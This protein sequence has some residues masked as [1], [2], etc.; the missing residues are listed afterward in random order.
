MFIKL[1]VQQEY[2][3]KKKL[4]LT[5]KDTPTQMF[6]CEYHKI[7]D[8]SFFSETPLVALLWTFL[9]KR[10]QAE[11]IIFQT[12]KDADV[13]LKGFFLLQLMQNSKEQLHTH[14]VKSE[15]TSSRAC[16][17]LV[18]SIFVI[19]YLLEILRIGVKG[20]QYFLIL[21]CKLSQFNQVPRL[22]TK[23]L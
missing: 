4:K 2:I 18:L 14:A 13:N 8:N 10:W 22:K 7:F 21:I 5:P 11:P 12:F 16:K 17:T 23:S 1:G 20:G 9:R 19:I 3:H 6:F 15:L